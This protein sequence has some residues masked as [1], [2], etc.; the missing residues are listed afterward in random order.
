MSD[1]VEPVVEILAEHAV[2][3]RLGEIAIGRGDQ[4][5]VDLDVARVADPTDLPL[6][7]RPQELH[8]DRVWNL[9]DLVE[10]QR[11][12]VGR[13]EETLRAGHGA[14]EGALHVAEELRFHQRLGNR[15]AVHRHER[16]G[17]TRRLQVHGARDQLLAGPALAG[18]HHRR[19]AVGRL[20]DRLE[21]LENARALADESFE[22]VLAS[23]LALELAVLVLQALALERVGD[24]EPQLVELE[25]LGDVVVGA[26][27]HR[28]HRRLGRGERGHHEH[29]RPRRVV[30]R[31]AQYGQAVHLAHP[32]IGDD[33]IEVVRLQGLHGGLAA[34][35]EGDVVADLPQHDAQ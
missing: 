13:R 17:P 23:Q 3:H 25:R 35:G 12:P 6:L 26:E 28:L 11:A 15:A 2:R 34:V 4:A 27:L 18:D 32:E 10:E 20:A 33:E 16:A 1:D 31:R 24:G 7:G 9:R 8:L 29:D 21:D 22:A 19:A 5:H 30:L 14:G